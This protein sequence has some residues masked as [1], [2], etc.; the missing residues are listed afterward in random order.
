MED[1][2]AVRLPPPFTGMNLADMGGSDEAR[3]A[4]KTNITSF[5]PTLQ[6]PL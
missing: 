2:P 4:W 1:S 3:V 5:C 6:L